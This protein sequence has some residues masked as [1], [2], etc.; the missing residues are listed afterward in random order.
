MGDASEVASCASMD[1]Q[2][3]AGRLAMYHA[4][5]ATTRA[6]DAASVCAASSKHCEGLVRRMETLQ[7]SAIAHAALVAHTAQHELIYIDQW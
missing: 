1:A 4:A 5:V 6:W 7:S 2:L 3:A